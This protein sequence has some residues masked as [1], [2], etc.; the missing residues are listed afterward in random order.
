VPVYDGTIDAGITLGETSQ[1]KLPGAP[2]GLSAASNW[3][4][5]PRALCVANCASSTP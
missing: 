3:S 1:P 4:S 5:Q 2:A